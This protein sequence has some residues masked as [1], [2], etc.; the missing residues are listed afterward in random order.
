MKRYEFFQKILWGGAAAALTGMVAAPQPVLTRLVLLKTSVAG[1]VYYD[2]PSLLH[3]LK[4][5]APVRL[6]REPANPYDPRAVE[7]YC[8]TAKLG[9]LPR[10]NNPVIASLMD[11]HFGLQAE[12]SDVCS[13]KDH[14]RPVGI[15]IFTL[16][17]VTDQP[18]VSG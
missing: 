2:G 11:Q 10:S 9:Y 14:Y 15:E 17:P 7:V 12:V 1:F 8:G 5:G 16:Q 18:C 4:P 3:S 13:D 6:Q